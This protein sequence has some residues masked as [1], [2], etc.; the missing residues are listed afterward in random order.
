MRISNVTAHRIRIPFRTTFAHALHARSEAEPIILTI[1]TETGER[2]VGEVLPRVYLTGETIQ[3]A[4]DCGIPSLTERW[5]GRTFED[6]AEVAAA[7]IQELPHVGRR[8][9]A[10]AG[11]ELALLDAAGKCFDFRVGELLGPLLSKELESGV[12]I[13]FGI[14]THELQRHCLLLRV[15]GKRQ[16]KVKVGAVDDLRRLD[17]IQG[18]LGPAQQLRLDANG[19]WSAD[20][21]IENVKQMRRFNVHSIEQPVTARDLAGMRRLREATGIRVVADES[22]CTLDDAR[23][24]LSESAADIFNI[25]IAKCGG[26]FACKQLVSLAHNA[27]LSCHLGTLVGETGILMRAA[28]I[29][30]QRVSGFD[31]LE[32]RDQ[33]KRLLAKDVV[34]SVANSSGLGVQLWSSTISEWSVSDP[35]VFQTKTRS[36]A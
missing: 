29:L 34:C 15:S 19:A 12:V 1:E 7:L 11:W 21:A 3:D 5:L 31:F 22:L 35:I 27:G 17:I 14:P 20:L 32:G 9:A 24:I 26:L 25:R 33:N 36:F 16:I 8:L 28:E 4:L 30:G 6:S 18:A 13:D 23:E 2:G 10:F